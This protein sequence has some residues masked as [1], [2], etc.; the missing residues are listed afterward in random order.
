[1]KRA[2]KTGRKSRS[3]GGEG[4]NCSPLSCGR[5]LVVADMMDILGQTFRSKLLA[6]TRTGFLLEECFEFLWKESMA[7]L[8]FVNSDQCS[9]TTSLAPT[10]TRESRQ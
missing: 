10:E 9:L 5:R 6:C 8:G 2:R 1:M 7:E 4:N 3:E